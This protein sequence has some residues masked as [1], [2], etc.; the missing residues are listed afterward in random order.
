MIKL[1]SI[2]SLIWKTVAIVVQ[3][4]IISAEAVY[5]MWAAGMGHEME[6]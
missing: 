6:I 3:C 4:H 1:G 2:E 5:V